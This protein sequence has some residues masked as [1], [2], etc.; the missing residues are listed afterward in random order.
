MS[1]TDAGGGDIDARV[2]VGRAWRAL[3]GLLKNLQTAA[4]LN[5]IIDGI[6]RID[7]NS[8]F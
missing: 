5:V 2:M 6:F 8:V 3:F 1:D 7:G 4:E